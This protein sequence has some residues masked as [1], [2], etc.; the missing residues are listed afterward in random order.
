MTDQTEQQEIQ[1]HG[2]DPDCIVGMTLVS[3]TMIVGLIEFETLNSVMIKF[4]IRVIFSDTGLFIKPF[5]PIMSNEEVEIQKSHIIS[6]YD[7]NDHFKNHYLS[8]I[9]IDGEEP[10]KQVSSRLH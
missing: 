5:C 1:E 4:P 3:D 8:A 10:Q 2:I 7:V 6:M 9:R